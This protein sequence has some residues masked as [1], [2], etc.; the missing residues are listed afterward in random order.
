MLWALLLL[1]WVV[2]LIW[3]AAVI[4]WTLVAI[5]IVFAVSVGLPTLWATWAVLRVAE[6]DTASAAGPGLTEIADRLAGQLR[7][8]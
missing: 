4:T 7:S 5:A 1:P 6:C 2:A 3:C 8:Q